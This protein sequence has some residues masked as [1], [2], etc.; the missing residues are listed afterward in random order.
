MKNVQT[1]YFSSERK[2]FHLE[3]W[4]VF[5]ARRR[6]RDLIGYAAILNFSILIFGVGL[7][8]IA[9]L[10]GLIALGLSIVLFIGLAVA[11]YRME[12]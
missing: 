4:R 1:G 6:K 10:V 8:M 9:G 2:P 5:H 12:E 7:F 3:C 11:Y